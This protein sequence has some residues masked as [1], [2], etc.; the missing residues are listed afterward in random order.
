MSNDETLSFPD[1]VYPL[2]GYREGSQLMT[3][4]APELGAQAAPSP[5]DALVARLSLRSRELIVRYETGGKDYYN[6]VIA[7]RPIWPGGASGVTIGCG[8]DLGYNAKSDFRNDWGRHLSASDVA[9]L[10]RT[11]GLT[12]PSARTALGR[13][14]HIRIP[15]GVALD[16]FDATT[17]PKFTVLTFERLPELLGLADAGL[18][19]DCLGALVSLVFN[20]GASFRKAGDRYQEMRA[21]RQAIERGTSASLGE[22]PR[23]LRDMKRIWQDQGLSGLLARR[24]DEAKLFE[25]GLGATPRLSV[26]EVRT[27]GAI[28]TT[29]SVL[30]LAQQDEDAPEL[31]DA[32]DALTQD[33]RDALL[34]EP[35]AGEETAEVSPGFVIESARSFDRADVAWVR[36]DR[37][38]PDYRHLPPDAAKSTFVLTPEDLDRMIAANR[39]QPQVGSHGKIVFALRGALLVGSG[40]S[41]EG[42][43]TLSLRDARPDHRTFRC[44]IGVYD[45][46]NQRLSGYTASTVPNAGGVAS[47]YRLMNG[48]QGAKANLLPTGCYELCVGTHFGSVTVKG[49]LRLG[50][51][52][53]PANAG[54]ATV[55]RSRDD[56]TFSTRDRWDNCKPADNVHPAF[57]TTTFSSL[58]CLTIMGSYRGSAGH[59]GEWAKFRTAAG[60]DSGNGEGTRFDLVLLTGL[61]AATAAAMRTAGASTDAIKEALT[62]LR[63]GSKGDE[64]KRLQQK[65]GIDA[66]GDFGPGTKLA[67]CK[68][69]FEKLGLATGVYSVEIDDDLGFGI[70]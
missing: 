68:A 66:D 8:Y 57:G 58:G 28:P 10:G 55:L 62:G 51:G 48:G 2:L 12:G 52:P 54:Q 64:V 3:G 11:I 17:L 63:H 36:D 5:A 31:F 56:V 16:V 45:R 4:L 26:A 23:H 20:R 15:W 22:I 67:L 70:F 6:R 41:Q 49:V 38:H 37:D 61:D 13:V 33:A 46:T 50:N 34:A 44:V 53:V 65:L 42:R 24:E 7:E 35:G 14:D 60:L 40:N 19:G 39:F 43:T 18:H 47:Y 69:Q 27:M 59:T 9:L 21:I 32:L 1:E 25:R 30:E 29:A